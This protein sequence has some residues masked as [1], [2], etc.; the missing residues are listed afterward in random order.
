MKKT[1]VI[2]VILFYAMAAQAQFKLHSSGQISFQSLTTTGGVQIEAS[3][4]CNFEPNITTSSTS[5]VQTKVQTP[6]V[7]AWNVRYTGNPAL[8][9]YD[10]FYV[11]G[12]GDVYSN[13]LYSISIGEEP[14]SKGR[15]PIENASELLSGL[16][17]YLFDSHPFEGFEPDFVGNPNIA[18]E[19]VEGMLK[20][21]EVDKALGLSADELE[22][23]LPE[24]IRHDP[25]GMVYIN[26][27]AVIPVLVEAFKEQQAKIEHLEEVLRANGLI[28]P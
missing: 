6:F 7:K 13:G 22:E 25:E 16:N 19:A 14:G 11:T 2:V 5:L 8:T 4:I 26:Y 28:E 20:D 17:G 21:L 27:S 3:G 1:I 12:A 15:Y 9:P 24:A 23:V 18:P 10:R